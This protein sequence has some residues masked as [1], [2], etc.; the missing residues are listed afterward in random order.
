MAKSPDRIRSILHGAR[1]AEL[2]LKLAFLRIT[3]RRGARQAGNRKQ[4]KESPGGR[5]GGEEGRKYTGRRR[6]APLPAP[7]PVPGARRVK[8]GRKR[9]ADHQ[10]PH[11]PTVLGRAVIRAEM[12][13]GRRVARPVPDS[14][15]AQTAR[16]VRRIG[17]IP[18][19]ARHHDPV[20]AIRPAGDRASRTRLARRGN[21]CGRARQRARTGWAGG[22]H[23][24]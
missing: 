6:W 18:V 7:R 23:S 22:W 4:G 5:T 11:A 12:D 9:C 8:S 16:A 21:P 3:A 19:V 1:A 2:S 17:G 24:G 14:D 13:I 20:A 15:R 10:I